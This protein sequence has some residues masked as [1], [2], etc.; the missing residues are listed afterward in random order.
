MLSD[1]TAISHFSPPPTFEGTLVLQNT[2]FPFNESRITSDRSWCGLGVQLLCTLGW[3]PSSEQVAQNHLS[4][5]RYVRVLLEV[6]VLCLVKYSFID[7]YTSTAVSETKLSCFWDT[8][9]YAHVHIHSHHF[10][11]SLAGHGSLHKKIVSFIICNHEAKLQFWPWTTSSDRRLILISKYILATEAKFVIYLALNFTWRLKK[12]FVVFEK[13]NTQTEYND[14]LYTCLYTKS[15]RLCVYR[16]VQPL[17][18][19]SFESKVIVPVLLSSFF[20]FSV[21]KKKP[22]TV[23]TQDERYD[24]FALFFQHGSSTTAA[25]PAWWNR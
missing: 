21:T 24:F 19:T 7:Y 14:E 2:G 16:F 10:Y 23:T 9:P 6:I 18:S 12:V 20:S 15:S 22:F 25:A 8:N 4:N 5:L 1:G 3:I 17:L 11:C 13:Y